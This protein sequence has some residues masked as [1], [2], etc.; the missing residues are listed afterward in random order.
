MLSCAWVPIDVVL[1]LVRTLRPSGG[2]VRQM[3]R[4][5]KEESHN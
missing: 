4:I 3:F 5:H 1:S 2:S